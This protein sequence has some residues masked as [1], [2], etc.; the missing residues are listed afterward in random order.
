MLQQ[1]TTNVGPSLT[2]STSPASQQGVGMMNE[3]RGGPGH[4]NSTTSSS[5]KSNCSSATPGQ[6]H[7]CCFGSNTSYHG[8]Q[9]QHYQDPQH[10]GCHVANNL[11]YYQTYTPV[12]QNTWYNNNEYEHY[13]N[14]LYDWNPDWNTSG[15]NNNSAAAEQSAA[16]TGNANNTAA[17]TGA[18]SVTSKSTATSP[19]WN[20]NDQYDYYSSYPTPPTPAGSTVSGKIIFEK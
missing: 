11:A 9:H 13:A 16:A 6:Q 7:C 5:F 12:Q 1:T 14:N 20:S 19:M 18:A 3:G 4:Q 15:G 10:R 2:S 8:P 17:S